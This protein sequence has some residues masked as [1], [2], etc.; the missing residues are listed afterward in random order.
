MT[1]TLF[2]LLLLLTVWLTIWLLYAILFTMYAWPTVQRWYRFARA[3]LSRHLYCPWCWRDRHIMRCY[4]RRWPSHLCSCHQQLARAQ[5][6]AQQARY[7]RYHAETRPAAP[8]L[9]A[10]EVCK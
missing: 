7:S 8:A 4:P 9:R 2:L 10:Q 5:M 1:R 6:A 3:G